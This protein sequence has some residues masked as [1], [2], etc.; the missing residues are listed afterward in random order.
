MNE[1]SH[2]PLSQQYERSEDAGTNES[3]NPTMGDIIAERLSRRDL[4]KGALAVTA[5]G[6]AISPL[7]WIGAREADAQT[8]STTPSFASRIWSI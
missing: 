4:M 8:A 5:I 6:A 3:A 1:L 2:L 7:A